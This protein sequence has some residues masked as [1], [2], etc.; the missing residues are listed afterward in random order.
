MPKIPVKFSGVIALFVAQAAFAQVAPIVGDTYFAPG[1]ASAFG[2]AITINVGGPTNYDGLVQFDLS[3]L[4]PG[5]TGASVRSASLRLFVSKVGAP[6]GFDLFATN[7]PWT[8]ATAS[9]VNSPPSGAL[10][11]GAVPV[12]LAGSWIVIDVTAQVQAW[13]NGAPN[14][15]FF[16]SANPA[17]TLISFDSKESPTTS[18][19]AALEIDLSGTAGP[20]G[21]QGA[22]GPTGPV[23][24]LGA[25]GPTG[26]VGASGIGGPTGPVGGTGAA[27]PAGTTGPAGATGTTGA[28]GAAGPTGLAG[29]NGLTGSTGP[30]GAAGSRGSTG[31][32]GPQGA[33]GPGGVAGTTGPQGTTGA[34]GSTGPQGLAGAAGANGPAGTTGA[35]GP[36]GALGAAGNPGA[37]GAAGPT[38]PTG[39]QGVIQNTV[40]GGAISI[41]NTAG[42]QFNMATSYDGDT[43][44]TVYFVNNTNQFGLVTLPHASVAGRVA[45]LIGKDYSTNGND[46]HLFPQTGQNIFLGNVTVCPTCANTFADIFFYARLISDGVGNWRV[47]DKQ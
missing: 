6:G 9:G 43:Q 17:S 20:A 44:G 31:A 21:L 16:F 28:I 2:T 15:G 24:P 7:G 42:T 26:A 13:L 40:T 34:I 19:P 37:P 22:R 1:N 38:G 25:A 8:E 18:H 23:G 45:I 12:T 46:L 35:L 30:P 33:T 11:A 4:P 41:G 47:T 10:I 32:T 27:G 36:Q 3:G 5:T 39:P 14:Y 29:P